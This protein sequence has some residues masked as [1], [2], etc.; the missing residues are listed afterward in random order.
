M[1][2][3]L[4]QGA[5]VAQMVAAWPAGVDVTVELGGVRRVL[6]AAEWL[7]RIAAAA[8]SSDPAPAGVF[9]SAARRA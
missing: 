4:T 8:V 2:P 7:W 3:L 9:L 6:D 1:T 5:A